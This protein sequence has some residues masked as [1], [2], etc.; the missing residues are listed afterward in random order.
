MIDER[1]SNSWHNQIKDRVRLALA[2][3]ELK[4][5]DHV[6]WIRQADSRLKVGL[7]TIRRAY[8]DLA[9]SGLLTLERAGR[10]CRPRCFE[11]REWRD[12]SRLRKVLFFCPIGASKTKAGT[13]RICTVFLQPDPSVRAGKSLYCDRGGKRR[14]G[15]R[16][17]AATK[18]RLA[19]AGRGL[20]DHR[21]RKCQSKK[22]RPF[23]VFSRTTTSLG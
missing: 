23:A 10:I 1:S 22:G 14:S 12:R 19:I 5:G 13:F 3:G 11:R 2:T 8:E 18:T 15:G 4:P 21:S 6:P 16:L 7:A 20:F 17:C 9:H